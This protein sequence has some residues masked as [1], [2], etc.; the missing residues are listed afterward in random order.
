[1]TLLP[2]AS[3]FLGA[4]LLSAPP[5]PN[6]LQAVTVTVTSLVST[7]AAVK[8]YFYNTREGFLKSGKWAFSK[9]VKPGGKSEFTLPVELPQGDWAVAITQDLNNNDKID[10]NFLGIPTEPYAF[11]NNVRPTVAAPD[12]NE[13]KFK[14]DGPGR[15]VNIVLKP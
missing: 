6:E 15:V 3:L 1:M 11:S 4:S 13:C 12:F 14:V 8:L 5:A 10:K 9:S 7:T 2:F